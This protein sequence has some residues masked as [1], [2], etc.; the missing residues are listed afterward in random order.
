M[1]IR[2]AGILGLFLLLPAIVPGQTSTGQIVRFKTSLGDIDVQLLPESAPKTVEN[3]MNYV[4][5]GAYNNS[6]IHRSVAGFVIQ[7]GGYRFVNQ[8]FSEIPSDPPVVNEYRLS[9]TRGTIAMAKLG[10][11]PNSATNQWFFNLANN[12]G[13]LNNQN[14]GF[15]VFGRIVNSSGLAIMDRIAAVRVPNPPIVAQPL[16]QMPLIGY[17]NGS[18]NTWTPV[19]ITSIAPVSGLTGVASASAFGAFREAAPGSFIEIYG[20]GL[21][22]T[23]REWTSSDFTDGAAPTTLEGV[24]VTIGGQAAYVYYVSPTQVNVQIP[25]NAPTSGTAQ[26]VVTTNGQSS[27]AMSLT[28]KSTAAGLLA[29]A[30]FKVGDKQYVAAIHASNGTFVSNGSVPDVQSAPAVPGETLTFYG[31]GFGPV[32]PSS[33]PYAGQ[34]ATGLAPLANPI[35]IFFGDI[36]ARVDY[37]GL[38]PSAV[39]LYQFNVIVPAGV[40][41]GDVPVRVVLGDQTLSQS[42]LLPVQTN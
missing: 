28:M 11:N 19:V 17:P 13:N 3:F 31:T 42:L 39:G 23:T 25:A 14:G 5:R 16:D 15:T 6:I 22:T 8:Q 34:I 30:S 20:S 32:T 27:T 38:A 1:T 29:P 12:A 36:Q 35:Q 33:F 40:A 21:A 41:S 37:A 24:S 26:V 4:N 7:G 2:L 10:D 9:N 18:P